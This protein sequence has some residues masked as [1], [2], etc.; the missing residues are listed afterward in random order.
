MTRATV[1]ESCRIDVRRW[2]REGGLAPG[3]RFGWGWADG[4]G[5]YRRILVVDVE[6]DRL[7]LRGHGAPRAIRLY[8]T[9]CHL[10]GARPWFRCPGC[11]RRAALLYLAG[12]RVDC[13]TCAGLAYASTRARGPDRLLVRAGALRRR[14]G[15]SSPL[16]PL[17]ARPSGMR[18]RAYRR[19]VED[20][21]AVEAAAMGAIVAERRASA[22]GLFPGL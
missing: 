11:G 4:A 22:D 2:Q 19:L 3:A 7:M 5:G 9:P 15:D 16:G 20:L 12:D 21:V 6:S 1:E 8:R 18:W 13:R 10:G 17:P 14:L